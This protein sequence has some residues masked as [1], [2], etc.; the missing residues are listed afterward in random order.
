[1]RQGTR[2]PWATIVGVVGHVKQ[3]D[4]AGDVVKGKYYYPIFQRPIPFMSDSGTAGV[5][6]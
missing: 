5:P 2:A 1:M 3:S 4:L 6:P